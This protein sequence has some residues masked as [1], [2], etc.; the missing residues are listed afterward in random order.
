[1]LVRKSKGFERHRKEKSYLNVRRGSNK[2]FV[3]RDILMRPEGRGGD[4]NG[5]ARVEHFRWGWGGGE[6]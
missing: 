6:E 2:H 3:G 1:M 4:S 5:K